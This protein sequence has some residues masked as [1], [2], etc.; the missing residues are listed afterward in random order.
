MAFLKPEA[1]AIPA[2]QQPAAPPPVLAPQGT[3]PGAKNQRTSFLG[4]DAMPQQN[5]GGAMGKTLLGQ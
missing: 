3:K 2:P 4:A 5:T 1:Q